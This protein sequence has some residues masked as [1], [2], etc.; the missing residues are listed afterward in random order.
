MNNFSSLQSAFFFLC[1]IYITVQA[2]ILGVTPGSILFF[3]GSLL[4]PANQAPRLVNVPSRLRASKIP[5]SALPP[6]DTLTFR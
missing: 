1:L 6:W 4:L 3:A 5:W 2:K